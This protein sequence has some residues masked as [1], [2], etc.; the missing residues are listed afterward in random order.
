MSASFR[1]TRFCSSHSLSSFL[2]PKNALFGVVQVWLSLSCLAL[3]L[4]LLMHSFG[5][6]FARGSF[7]PLRFLASPLRFSVDLFRFPFVAGRGAFS[8]LLNGGALNVGTRRL[9]Q[10]LTDFANEFPITASS[11]ALALNAGVIFAAYSSTKR[12]DL[13]AV[14]PLFLSWAEKLTGT[15]S[16]DA[17]YDNPDSALALAA[18]AASQTAMFFF[19]SKRWERGGKWNSD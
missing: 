19:C 13:A 12:F 9:F 8:S 18:I 6:V 5:R 14:W 1:F 7:D 10:E 16:S 17:V 15:L 11:G 2:V 4:I 3:T